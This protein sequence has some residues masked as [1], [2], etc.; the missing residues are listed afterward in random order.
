[1]MK[2]ISTILIIVSSV[3]SISYSF[4][5]LIKPETT[6]VYNKA[7]ISNLGIQLLSLFLGIGGLLLLF[8]LT[9]KL[10]G[11]MLIVHSL[12]TIICFIL[13]R[14]WRGGILEFVFLQIP[15]FILWTGYPISVLEKLKQLLTGT[16][17]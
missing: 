4:V 7:N 15:V 13:I 3:A 14:D 10:G 8:P 11:T 16:M 2:A 6:L 5:G 17:E 9:F 1:M 12:I